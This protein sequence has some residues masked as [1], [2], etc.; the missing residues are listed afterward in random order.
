MQRKMSEVQTLLILYRKRRKMQ[1][2]YR[3][4]DEKSW[5]CLLCFQGL[6]KGPRLEEANSS[7][8][9]ALLGCLS[10]YSSMYVYTMLNATRLFVYIN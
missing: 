4:S 10:T 7:T 2:T 3:V 6:I 5:S 1:P 9:D 8:W